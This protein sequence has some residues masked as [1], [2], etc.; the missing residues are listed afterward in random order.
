MVFE[1][2][3]RDFRPVA[4]SLHNR[5]DRRALWMV[6]VGIALCRQDPARLESARHCLDR[7]DREQPSRKRL[8][9]AWRR[10]LESTD[11]LASVIEPSPENQQLRSVCPLA[12][13]LRPGEHPAALHFFQNE[14][15]P[16]LS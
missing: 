11:A 10:L 1:A 8:F 12:G 13:S 4:P 14:L 9:S 3:L 2:A 16:N 6:C 15:Y 5:S 7:W